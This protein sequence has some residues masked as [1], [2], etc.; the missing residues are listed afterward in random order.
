MTWLSVEEK[1][2]ASGTEGKWLGLAQVPPFYS[3]PFADY[4]QPQASV[5]PSRHKED[6]WNSRN[7][8]ACSGRL[9]SHLHGEKVALP[10]DNGENQ[11][12][13]PLC[14]SL[15]LCQTVRMPRLLNQAPKPAL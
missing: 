9:L 15:S 11:S 6:S 7:G 14:L 2:K 12:W 8:G 13:E 4:E 5:A 10:K 1:C 3:L